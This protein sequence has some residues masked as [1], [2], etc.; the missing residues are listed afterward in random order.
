MISDFKFFENLIFLRLSSLSAVIFCALSCT[1]VIAAK[2]KEEEKEKGIKC[3][4]VG[5][6]NKFTEACCYMRGKTIINETNM[7]L[8]KRNETFIDAINFNLNKRIEFLPVRVHEK[9]PHINTYLANRCSIKSISKANFEGLVELT[10]VLLGGNQIEVVPK[11]TFEGL[12]NL[13]YLDFCKF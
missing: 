3:E 5:G 10:D 12:V 9:F 8:A 11:D 13:V 4:W 2:N 6:Y 1:L 7:E